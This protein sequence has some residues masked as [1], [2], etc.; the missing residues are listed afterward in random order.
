MKSSPL[1]VSLRPFRTSAWAAL[2]VLGLVMAVPLAMAAS[3]SEASPS[4]VVPPWSA[5]AY[6]G[7]E[8]ASSSGSVNTDGGN[9]TFSFHGAFGESVVLNQ[10]NTSAS[11]YSLQG[12]ETLGTE[13]FVTLCTPSCST[14]RGEA[15][16]TFFSYLQ[17]RSYANLTEAATVDVNGTAVPAIGL[18]NDQTYASGNITRLM[19]Y[20]YGGGG[21][22]FRSGSSHNGFS[23]GSAQASAV[24]SVAFT[25]ALGVQPQNVTPG[26]AW[27]SN[28]SYSGQVVANAAYHVYSTVNGRIATGTINP[29]TNLSGSLTLSGG[30]QGRFLLRDGALAHQFAF[31]YN[32][33]FQFWD[34]IFLIPQGANLFIGSG[35]P[36][37]VQ[38]NLG[39][40][41]SPGAVDYAPTAGHFGWVS[42]SATFAPDQVNVP[43]GPA[44]TAG[45][46][47]LGELAQPT[48][49]GG[50]SAVNLQTQPDSVADAQALSGA[51]EQAPPLVALAPLA[52]GHGG[53]FLLVIVAV[54][55]AAVVVLLV[56]RRMRN[57]S[58]RPRSRRGRGGGGYS[59]YHEARSD[60]DH[61][62][63]GP[64]SSA[65]S[66]PA[67]P[68]STKDDPFSDV[69]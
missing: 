17:D 58:E 51:L 46:G 38:G 48:V 36:W 33:P 12:M 19:Q 44:S 3:P 1:P 24:E 35:H 56:V 47:D 28:S 53:V 10:T 31:R 34:G 13:Y 21:G 59:G 23:Y 5:W 66:G 8:V 20:T 57:R 41:G 30:D 9:F 67:S 42:G 29:S 43:A 15:N 65:L 60:R 40:T 22:L 55:V 7:Y 52:G 49:S 68:P 37:E 50:P 6:T 54:V 64:S 45:V 39:V 61:D 26:E 27:Q 11:T 2:A 32:A 62:D 4:L 25:P 69:V 16:I 18:V 63:D 14:P